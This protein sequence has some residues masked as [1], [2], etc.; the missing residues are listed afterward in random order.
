MNSWGDPW[1]HSQ[2]K[3]EQ[4]THQ[5]RVQ[6]NYLDIQLPNQ[7]PSC[8]QSKLH[9]T[10]S[11]WKKSSNVTLM[12]KQMRPGEKKVFFPIEEHSI[13]LRKLW[14]TAQR[15]NGHPPI[16]CSYKY[17]MSC[18]KHIINQVNT[19]K[20]SI[21][22]NSFALSLNNLSIWVNLSV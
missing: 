7:L 18:F 11:T 10:Q 8:K 15:E 6:P 9:T 5:L 21:F 2:N 16:S 1:L 13:I 20:I 19:F 22:D 4:V 14:S 17:E 12:W 3:L